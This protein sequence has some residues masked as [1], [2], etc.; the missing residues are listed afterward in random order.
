MAKKRGEIHEEH[1]DESWLVPYCDLLTLLLALF[2]VL[3]A[4]SNTDKAKMDA[5]A[6][7]FREV[8]WSGGG[9]T[10]IPSFASPATV[11]PSPP[12]DEFENMSAEEI[13]QAQLEEVQRQLE[14]YMDQTGLTS[15]VHTSI[16]QR[17]LVI[18]LNNALFFDSASANIRPEHQHILIDIGKT[19]NMM[20]NYIRI[21]G[22]TDTVP[23][24][25]ERFPSNWELS[26]ARAS[27]LVRLFVDE[28][29][30][31]PNKLMAVGYGEFKPIASN[32]TPEGRQ[33]NR[34]VDVIV[35]SSRYDGLE[36]DRRE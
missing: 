2:V 12:S 23:I 5:L 10:Y 1:A 7:A 26:S 19:V 11:V 32:A 33:Q 27:A 4:M 3:F 20:P 9:M 15:E 31:D 18:S 30:V 36:E 14:I 16:D 29:G 22:H 17:G 35:L 28:S 13:E 34:R 8:I 21:E 24:R 25:T 6:T